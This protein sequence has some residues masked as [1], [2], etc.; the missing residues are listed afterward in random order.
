MI[1][2]YIPVWFFPQLYKEHTNNL[3]SENWLKCMEACKYWHFVG[4]LKQKEKQE[5]AG[6]SGSGY[7]GGNG[8]GSVGG[9]WLL[10]L[11]HFNMLLLYLVMQIFSVNFWQCIGFLFFDSE[12]TVVFS[13]T[14]W[15]FSLEFYYY[16]HILILGIIDIFIIPHPSLNGISFHLF[17]VCFTSVSSL[18]LFS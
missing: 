4:H 13:S 3:N 8:R 17:K 10:F 9:I 18:W 12:Y 14:P 15:E 6:E 1:I 5:N 7:R 2:L 16:I 11:C